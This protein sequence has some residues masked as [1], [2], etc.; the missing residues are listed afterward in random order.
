MYILK[1]TPKIG[2]YKSRKK[3][4]LELSFDKKE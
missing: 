4:I 3:P 2:K 1:M